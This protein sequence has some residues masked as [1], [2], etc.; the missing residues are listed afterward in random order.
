MENYHA[1]PGVE[2]AG[3]GSNA[4]PRQ[5]KGVHAVV[6]D[7]DHLIRLCLLRHRAAVSPAPQG[8]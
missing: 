1:L 6:G 5:G 4:A 3:L 2:N 8:A 7:F